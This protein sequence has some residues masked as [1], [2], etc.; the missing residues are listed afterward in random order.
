MVPH[1]AFSALHQAS[2]VGDDVIDVNDHQRVRTLVW[3]MADLIR[4]TVSSTDVS[5]IHG[6]IAVMALSST[7]ASTLTWRRLERLAH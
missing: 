3:S 7:A 1:C 6:S 2:G 4:P 5:D